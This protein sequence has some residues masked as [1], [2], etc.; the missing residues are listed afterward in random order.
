MCDIQLSLKLQLFKRRLFDAFK[1]DKAEHKA[2]S[3]DDSDEEPEPDLNYAHNLL[4]S[5]LP[6]FDFFKH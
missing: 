3:D 2:K 4:N 6:N 5:L 1:R